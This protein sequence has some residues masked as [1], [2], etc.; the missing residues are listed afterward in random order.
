MRPPRY[1]LLPTALKNRG[2][3]G[4]NPPWAFPS[5]NILKKAP[6]R[7]EAGGCNGHDNHWAMY[8]APN[9]ACSRALPEDGRD[10]ASVHEKTDVIE[11]WSETAPYLD[12]Y[13][14]IFL[15][16]SL[17]GN[18]FADFKIQRAILHGNLN[19]RSVGDITFQNHLGQIV[20]QIRL[21]NAF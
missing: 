16:R 8:I 17:T 11:I 1:C 10:W 20:L 19:Q 3:K 18:G 2:S 14:K 9:P 12:N 6:T 4:D 15:G 5:S 7:S 21:D 13:E